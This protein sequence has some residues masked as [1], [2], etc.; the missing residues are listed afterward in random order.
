M[1]RDER[2]L[3]D[4]EP[5]LPVQHPL[6]AAFGGWPVTVESIGPFGT[7]VTAALLPTY[8]GSFELLAGDEWTDTPA[9]V[10]RGGVGHSSHLLAFSGALASSV[11]ALLRDAARSERSIP[12]AEGREF[13]M[14]TRRKFEGLYAICTEPARRTLQTIG[15]RC[16]VMKR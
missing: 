4:I 11:C 3:L 1:H 6:P 2:L 15:D 8:T 12:A 9:I 14:A 16:G 7:R 5:L 13:S 10:I